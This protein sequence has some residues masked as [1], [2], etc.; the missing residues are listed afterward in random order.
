MLKNITTSLVNRCLVTIVLIFHSAMWSRLLAPEGRG[1]FAKIQAT[2]G[3][4]ILFLGFGLTSG[5]V[6][7]GA[8]KAM[9]KHELRDLSL[10]V[11]L[12][13]MIVTIGLLALSALFPNADLIFPAGFTSLFFLFYFLFSFFQSQIQVYLNA[14][15]VAE[16]E[17]KKINRI[18]LIS[19]LLR[20]TLIAC[21]F[22]FTSKHFDIRILFV[23]DIIAQTLKTGLYFT[24]FKW[25]KFN[26]PF[27]WPHLA[28]AWPVLKYSGALYAIYVIQFIYQRIDIW[29]V[30]RWNGLS[31]LGIFSSALG[32]AQYVTL[33][34]VVLN[35]V[36]VPSLAAGD[37]QKD[38]ETLA[39]FSRANIILLIFPCLILFIFSSQIIRVLYG[40]PFAEADRPLRLLTIGYFFLSIKHV[41]IYGL[42]FRGQHKINMLIEIFGLF[43]GLAANFILVPRYGVA[44]AS[45]AFII[46]AVVTCT[47]AILAISGASL[48]K[49]IEFCIPNPQDIRDLMSSFKF[50]LV[51]VLPNENYTNEGGK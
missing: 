4:L 46:S 51:P 28:K 3:F 17:F 18:E 31:A 32:L 50:K 44:G 26:Q 24:F 37:K 47:S 27:R 6:H 8:S 43:V 22:F 19:S 38:Q 13:A 9:A 5:I 45:F 20:L 21:L 29:M 10:F 15:L 48:K 39:L 49:V 2:Q 23:A 34:P 16:H 36:L 30:E 40:I 42:A 41:F 11:G 12:L 25:Q 14:F 35:S 1:L 7:F 33:I